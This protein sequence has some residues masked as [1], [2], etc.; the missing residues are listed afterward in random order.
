MFLQGYHRAMTLCL[1]LIESVPPRDGPQCPLR[2]GSTD[3]AVNC[4]HNYVTKE[5]HFGAISRQFGRVLW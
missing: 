1:A 2:V 5:N 3:V 4:H